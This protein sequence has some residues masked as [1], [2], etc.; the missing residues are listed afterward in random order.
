M[1]VNMRRTVTA[2]ALFFL[3]AAFDLF[4]KSLAVKALE[5][6]IHID[7]IK[8]VL[9]FYYI[10]N[11]GAAFGIF[12]DGTLILGIISA[13]ALIVLFILYC[14]T[15]DGRKYLPLRIVLVFI[16]AGAAGN[17]FDRITLHYV[18]DFIYFSL[19]DFPVF[20]VAD[21]YVTCSV[22]VLAYLILFYYQDEDLA[23]LGLKGDSS[24]E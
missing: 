13:A 14:R 17:L 18:R 23:F 8:G 4:T 16:S 9:E 19:I 10:Q 5:G 1:S 2:A 20:N 22:F 12:Q 15:P 24:H 3:L 11:R 7:L 6:G 21:I